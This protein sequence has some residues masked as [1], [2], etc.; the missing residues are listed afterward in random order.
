MTYRIFKRTWWKDRAC[1]VPGPGRRTYTGNEFQ[2]EQEARDFCRV[3]GER[4]F[5]PT[6]RGVAC[7]AWPTNT[8]GP[9]RERNPHRYEARQHR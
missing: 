1:T 4:E 9:S 6:R 7:A 8:R 2:T 5:G 3:E